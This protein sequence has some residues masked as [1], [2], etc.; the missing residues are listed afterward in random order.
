[1]TTI[2]L[3]IPFHLADPAGIVFFAHSFTLAHQ[4][5]EQWVQ[6]SLNMSW[7]EWF[8]NPQ[9]VAPI[10]HTE[11]NYL[12]PLFAGQECDVNIEV[13]EI[14][15]SSF[16]ISYQISQQNKICCELTIT[17]VFCDKTTMKKISIPDSIKIA[18]QPRL[19]CVNN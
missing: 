11:A 14:K 5:F 4:A 18:L 10:R 13:K 15:N 3:F 1:M 17:Q 12:A 19:C 6:T 2:K 9:W 7:Q 8:N 16:T